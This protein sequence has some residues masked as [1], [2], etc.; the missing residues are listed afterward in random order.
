MILA[1]MDCPA[2]VG[3]V[4]NIGSDQPV[5]ILD[6]AR[7]VIAAVDPS[8]EVEFISYVQAYG[9]D[10]ED[11]RRRVPDLTKLR[12]LTGLQARYGLDNIIRELVAWKRKMA[13]NTTEDRQ[14]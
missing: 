14:K 1:L 3:G 10:F 9:E 11:C 2:A 6:L 12:T 8:L 7:Q 5:S 13:E 4:V